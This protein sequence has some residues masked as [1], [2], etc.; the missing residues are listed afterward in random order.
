MVLKREFRYFHHRGMYVNQQTGSSSNFNLQSFSSDVLIYS[1]GQAVLLIFG[2]IQS[3]IIPKYLSTNDY[4]YWQLFQLFTTYTGILHL[5]FL[6]GL[7]VRWA[8]KDLG[9]FRE[10]IPTSFS[11]I[12]LE[13]GFIV[14][15]LV[16][17]VELIDIPSKEIALAV[18]AN[19]II[20]NLLMYFL[21]I[22]QA[23]KRFKLVSAAN[24]GRGLLFIVFVL[25][26]FFSGHLSY[27]SLILAN[28]T[29]EIS[30]LFMFIFHT[31]DCLFYHNTDRKSLLQYG[32]ENI[33]VGIFVLLGN[34]IA[35][36][37]TTIDRMTVG[38]FFPITQFAIYTFAM[39][40]CG[41]ITVFLQAVAQV[42]FPYLSG[43]STETRKQA[44]GI[45]RSAL[46][47]FWAGMLAAYFPLSV[48]ITYYLPHYT[49]SIPL[50][51]ILFCAVGFSGQINIL[52]ANFFKVYRKQRVYFVLA[53]ISLIGTGILNLLAVSLFGTLNA[54]A[55]TAVVSFSLWYL[56]NEVAL[57]HLVA[58]PARE[59]VKWM[60]VIGA[61]IG[62]FI[63][64][65]AVAE[66]WIIEFGIYGVLF[67][68]ITVICLHK[69]IKQLWSIIL[70]ITNWRKIIY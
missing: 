29:T 47:I 59:I 12:L 45:L 36:I 41:L 16:M 50:I 9:A 7:L 44:Y 5:G 30:I 56:L 20:Y 61:Y 17:T 3:L 18:L 51:A 46:V 32:K 8:G 11:F 60:L 27:F 48:G 25:L 39:S 23:T 24:I 34:F 6:D 26:I 2:V 57:R 19:G 53:G 21:F 15:V 55:A 52:H 14:G 10:E 40:M 38:S 49:D 70:N 54:V 66:T 33:G 63:G 28:M 64:A 65:Y 43:S 35:V 68:G 42:F 13:Q 4:G 67:A 31:R 1:F 22:A 58:I 69:E 62:A 37:F